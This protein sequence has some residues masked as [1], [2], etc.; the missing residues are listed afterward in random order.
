MT[1]KVLIVDDEIDICY[2]LSGILRQKNYKTT[3]V[4]TLSD[5]EVMLKRDPP[6]IVF[7]DNHLPDGLG[8]DFIQYI[9]K[10]YPETKIVMV[11]AN[12]TATD[13]QKAFKQG[14]NYFMGKPFTREMVY[15][16]IEILTEEKA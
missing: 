13:R 4:N 15:R 10:Y 16:V 8:V 3:Y 2:L 5:A 6:S 1:L 14:V 7:L 11:T 12:D 9:K